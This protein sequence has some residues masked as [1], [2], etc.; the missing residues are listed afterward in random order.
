MNRRIVKILALLSLIT[1]SA[2]TFTY[3]PPI[4]QVQTRTPQLEFAAESG[5]KFETELS[6]QLS[7]RTIPESGWLAVQWFSPRNKEL[8]SDS[9]WLEPE[10]AGSTREIFLPAD[11]AL[12]PG[13]WRA[14]VSFKG[15]IVRQFSLGLKKQ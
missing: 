4:P 10:D 15:Q 9:I 12:T 14:L 8:A 3:L 13:R 11:I 6:L 1:L 7:L 5:L 2:C